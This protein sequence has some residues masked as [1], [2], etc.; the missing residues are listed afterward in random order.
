MCI[1]LDIST[2]RCLKISKL[3]LGKFWISFCDSDYIKRERYLFPRQRFSL[4]EVH[5]VHT[6]MLVPAIHFI[7][8]RKVLPFTRL[9]QVSQRFLY[10]N[11]AFVLFYGFWVAAF[12]HNVVRRF[13]AP[14]Q[15]L[16]CV[17]GL[18]LAGLDCV[19]DVERIYVVLLVHVE[20]HVLYCGE[21]VQVV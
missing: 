19:D 10:S 11:L 5:Q 7:N 1:A 13:F 3:F 17:Y 2:T 18:L 12:L 6:I 21:N 14:F 20:L 8:A 9:Q 16:Y 4:H 15:V